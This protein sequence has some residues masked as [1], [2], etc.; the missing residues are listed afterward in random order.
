MKELNQFYQNSKADI[1]LFVWIL[2]STD[3]N[4]IIIDIKS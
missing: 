4:S 3:H 1:F 2:H